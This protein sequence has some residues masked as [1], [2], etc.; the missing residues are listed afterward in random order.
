[1]KSEFIYRMKRV[2]W[3]KKNYAAVPNVCVYVC[4]WFNQNIFRLNW[5]EFNHYLSLHLIRFCAWRSKRC[6][7][8]VRPFSF[9]PLYIRLIIS[10]AGEKRVYWRP[11]L[12]NWIPIIESFNGTNPL[13]FSRYSKEIIQNMY[14]IWSA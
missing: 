2:D 11:K 1:M 8:N 12:M 7:N 14:R 9:F 4:V 5:F 10:D 6:V 13:N 3:R